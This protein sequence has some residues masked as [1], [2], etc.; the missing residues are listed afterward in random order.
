VTRSVINTI[1]VVK[2]PWNV[3]CQRALQADTFVDVMSVTQAAT[4]NSPSIKHVLRRGGDHLS[5]D[6]ATAQKIEVSIQVVTSKQ[7]SAVAG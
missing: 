6:L 5:V 4:V 1:R 3:S 2:G 7:D